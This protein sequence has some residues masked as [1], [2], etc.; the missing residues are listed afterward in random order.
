MEEFGQRH[1][2][3]PLQKLGDAGNGVGYRRFGA[4]QIELRTGEPATN[5]IAVRPEL[6]VQLH[7]DGRAG[8][9]AH[10]ADRIAVPADRLISIERPGDR[11]ED[12]RLAGAVRAD[13]AG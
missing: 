9:R 2:E 4:I 3:A 7:L 5:A 8:A 6:E 10:E 11:F 1:A 12:R 13:D